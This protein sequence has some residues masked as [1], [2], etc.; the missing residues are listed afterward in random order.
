[1]KTIK[2]GF[3]SEE[4]HSYTDLSGKRIISTTQVFEVLGMVD[5]SFVK[6]DVLERKS[7]IGIATHAAIQYLCEGQ[8]DWESLDETV[9]PY[10]EAYRDWA[11]QSRFISDAQEEQGI[12][13]I[14]GMKY[15]WMLDSRGEMEF[16]GSRVPVIVDFKTC[17]AESPTWKLQLAAYA[18]AAPKL[19]FISTDYLRVVVQLKKDGTFKPYYYEEKNDLRAW[20]HILYS[21]I[22]SL[23]NGVKEL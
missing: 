5:Y 1:M 20:P 18:L 4:E 12:H 23:N 14:A 6:E 7:Q 13:E 19:N 16:K 2:N 9:R 17:V 3:F 8:L 15:G 21:A 11:Y 22:W 10:V